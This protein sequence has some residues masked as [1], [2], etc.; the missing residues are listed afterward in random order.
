LGKLTADGELE[1]K[2]LFESKVMTYVSHEMAKLTKRLDAME[3]G[4]EAFVTDKHLEMKT[5]E[6]R[7]HFTCLGNAISDM[8]DQI[9]AAVRHESDP[10]EE[11]SKSFFDALG[12]ECGN[13]FVMAINDL[14][15]QIA[16]AV[17]HEAAL[18][19][20]VS[21]SFFDALGKEC[22]NR[23]NDFVIAISVMENQITAAVR[24]EAALREE[25]SKS[26][27]D[28]LGKER[29]NRRHDL[30]KMHESFQVA[31]SSDGSTHTPEDSSAASQ[32]NSDHDVA[33]MT[34]DAQHMS[35]T[36]G[37]DWNSTGTGSYVSEL[38]SL[39]KDEIVQ[40]Q[41]SCGN[42]Q[43]PAA[44]EADLGSLVD[45]AFP[46][47]SRMRSWQP[48][49]EDLQTVAASGAGDMK[50]TAMFSMSRTQL[51]ESATPK[52]PEATARTQSTDSTKQSKKADSSSKLN[53][54]IRAKE[55]EIMIEKFNK[56]I[57]C[58]I[59]RRQF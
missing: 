42:Q 22:D 18:R 49:D 3:K 47:L 1:Q 13:D 5:A 7:E 35:D 34:N 2:A 31:L 58:K 51:Y 16:A 9:T 28:A 37:A 50:Y 25:L 10:R 14:E 20:E 38:M 45:T 30:W 33:Q 26:F 15:N 32:T 4:I 36:V 41:P 23:R 56:S 53:S 59:L 46:D 11:M 21:K 24:N 43:S 29:D 27:F 54:T 48:S 52:K 39:L 57:G 12:K 8:E 55:K 40:S 17:R 6:T 19:E 44:T